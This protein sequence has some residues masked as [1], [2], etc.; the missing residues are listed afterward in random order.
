MAVSPAFL[1]EVLRHRYD[2]RCIVER[3]GIDVIKG[4]GEFAGQEICYWDLFNGWSALT[5]KQ[6][7]A[8]TLMV[9]CDYDEKESARILGFDHSRRTYVADR[10]D[11]GMRR[12]AEFH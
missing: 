4:E 8:I 10:V 1:R 5:K 6:Q 11:A 7:E 2:F 12:L 9:L 3:Y